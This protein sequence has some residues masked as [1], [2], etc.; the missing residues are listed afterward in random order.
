MP[1]GLFLLAHSLFY[2]CVCVTNT[3]NDCFFAS[4]DSAVQE[5][6]SSKITGH[7][8]GMQLLEF[9][10]YSIFVTTEAAELI[11]NYLLFLFSSVQICV[12]MK[13]T[14]LFLSSFTHSRNLNR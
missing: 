9:E 5:D 4:L 6:H 3:D 13:Q 7:M 14:A 1:S 10:M 12:V 2:A 11:S 8:T